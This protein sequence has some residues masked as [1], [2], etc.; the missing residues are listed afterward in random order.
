MAFALL[1][2]G[3]AVGDDSGARLDVHHP[4]L[5]H[6]SA[7]HDAAVDRAVGGEIAD[8][9]GVGAT[10]FRFQLG[11]DLAGA[12]F[13]GAGDGARRKPREQRIERVVLG[14]ELS[15]NVA[16][17]V[18]H[19]AV[20][21]DG[22]ARGHPHARSLGNP[23]DIVAAEVEQHQVF[24]PLFRVCEQAFLVLAVFLVGPPSRAG[25]GDR[26][27]R[28]FAVAHP[29]ED[30]G[31][32]ADHREARQ[33][34]EVEERR[35]VHPPKRA[36]ERERRQR[37]RAG[38]PLSQHHLEDVPGLDVVLRAQHHRL[39][40]VGRDHR[41]ER[42][43]GKRIVLQRLRARAGEAPEGLV[44]TLAGKLD[45]AR[46]IGVPGPQRGDAM[47][48][49][50]QPVEH[51]HQRRSHDQDVGHLELASRGARQLLDEADG[52]VGEIAD[53]ACE[54]GGEALGH[55]DPAGGGERAQF[56]ERACGQR[57][58]RRAVVLPAPID[59]ARVPRR[60]EHQVGIEPQ[61]AV[62]PAGV[63]ALDRFE[64]EV[65]AARLDQLERRAHRGLGVRHQLAPDQRRP[66]LLE[67]GARGPGVLWVSSGQRA[68]PA[69][70]GR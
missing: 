3:V 58:E 48:L 37:E 55:V 69:A 41:L 18:H 27:D 12:D 64:Q 17:D 47:E 10:G 36:V 57:L 70:G 44:D 67:L 35:G 38:E 4:V 49:V 23:A 6:R 31:A 29:H 8:A 32:R 66:A 26:A 20:A 11:N 63:A 16:D 30:F 24:G 34:E 5:H 14:G 9:A 62:A 45:R 60:A 61:Q 40:L 25:A 51:Q 59:F 1:V 65:A 53:Q 21:F 22:V 52:L 7:Q 19:V 42:H 39:V 13:G 2:S 33:V 43:F 56:F 28:H 50:G 54:R 46:W 15:D 68:I